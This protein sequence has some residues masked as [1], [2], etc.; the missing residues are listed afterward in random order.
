M[1]DGGDST[2]FGRGAGCADGAKTEGGFVTQDDLPF[3]VLF[4]I[5]LII[6]PQFA[7]TWRKLYLSVRLDATLQN[8]KQALDWMNA[9]CCA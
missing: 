6:V 1:F 3:I 8:E 4:S 2:T 5:L 9:C 7:I